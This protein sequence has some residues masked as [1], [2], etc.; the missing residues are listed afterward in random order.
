VTNS[1]NHEP[2]CRGCKYNTFKTHG[3]KGKV[4]NGGTMKNYSRCPEWAINEYLCRPGVKT[5]VMNELVASNRVE[6]RG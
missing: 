5:L 3:G 1:N 4:C 6:E 2:K